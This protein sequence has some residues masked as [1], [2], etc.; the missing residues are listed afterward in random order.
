MVRPLFGVGLFPW[1]KR[2]PTYEEIIGASRLA[3]KLGYDAVHIPYHLVFPKEW[4]FPDF[5]NRYIL[6]AIPLV[7]SIAAAT[8]RIKVALNSSVA[9]LF[10]SYFSARL[11][12]TIDHISN[13]RLIMGFAPG[14]IKDEFDVSGVAFDERSQ[15]TDEYLQV[16]RRLL[17]EK[18]VTFEGKFVNLQHANVEP[19]PIQKPM[20]PIW[21]G[22]SKS[23]VK[24]AAKYAD[25]LCLY[26]KDNTSVDEIRN[27]TAPSLQ[28]EAKAN[29]RTCRLAMYT[30]AAIVE[31]ERERERLM[32]HI[33]RGYAGYAGE[34]NVQELSIVG[35][36]DECIKNAKRLISAGISYLV[37]DFYSHG[38]EDV[39]VLQGRMREFSKKVIAKV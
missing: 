32:H 24:R 2:P 28:R 12:S 19:K 39:S 14:W 8:K 30:Y 1:G 35:S 7:A 11:I 9:P 20:P 17:T 33:R 3:E 21:I 23:S 10:N 6:D 29:N 15:I 25:Y 18:E 36:T 34:S 27:V 5:G 16:I 37:L 4:I 13:G 22:G 38:M 26:C 31:K